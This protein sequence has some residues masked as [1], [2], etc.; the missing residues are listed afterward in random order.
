MRSEIVNVIELLHMSFVNSP[1]I[2]ANRF[3]NVENETTKIH[4]K[5]KE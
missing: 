5:E 2:D 1:S 3:F 4:S